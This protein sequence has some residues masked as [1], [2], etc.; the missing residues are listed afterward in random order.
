M[1]GRIVFGWLQSKYLRS[2][3]NVMIVFNAQVP[4]H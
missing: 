2:R 1:D 3:E 4:S